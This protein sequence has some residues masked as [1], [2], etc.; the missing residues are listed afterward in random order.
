[1]KNKKLF[2]SII[3]F[4]VFLIVAVILYNSLSEKY[5]PQDS[6][7]Q[8]EVKEKIPAPDIS[9]FD[10]RGE[11]IKLSSYNGKPVV[12]NFWA[13]WCGPCRAELPAFQ[14]MYDK[15]GEKIQ[16][17][18][19]NLTDGIEETKE[20]VDFFISDGGYTFPVFY[21]LNQSAA[22]AYSVSSVPLTVFID[23]EGNIKNMRVGAMNE[24]MLSHYID[25]LIG[26]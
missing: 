26:G 4:A 24:Q 20:E 14:T 21:D 5:V 18:M 7:Q 22:Y 11:E 19:V 16:F 25:E 12:M 13:T 9:V 1:M 6:L 8:E 15:Y 3:I 17:F 2:I 10:K 23:K